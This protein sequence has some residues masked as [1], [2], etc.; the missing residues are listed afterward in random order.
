MVADYEANDWENPDASD[1][2]EG[3]FSDNFTDREISDESA[4]AIFLIILSFVFLLCF[5]TLCTIFWCYCKHVAQ[6]RR[7]ALAEAK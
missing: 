1:E 3:N 7:T 6:K 5:V 4:S 2:S